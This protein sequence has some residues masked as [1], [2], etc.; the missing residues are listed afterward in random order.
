MAVDFRRDSEPQRQRNNRRRRLSERLANA[1][2]YLAT[3]LVPVAGIAFAG[4]TIRSSE[5]VATPAPSPSPKLSDGN[6]LENIPDAPYRIIGSQVM[7]D[8]TVPFDR[9]EVPETPLGGTMTTELQREDA[10]PFGTEVWGPPGTT[11]HVVVEPEG[12]FVVQFSPKK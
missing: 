10:T 6:S 12:K 9:V 11:P 1:A 8:A 2:I 3:A 5:K 7:F 4:S